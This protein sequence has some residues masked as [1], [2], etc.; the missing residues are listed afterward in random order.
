[1][2]LAYGHRKALGAMIAVALL[3]PVLAVVCLQ[4][5]HPVM[6]GGF[7]GACLTMAHTT[8]VGSLVDSEGSTSL[9]SR[10]VTA[11]VAFTALF[12]VPRSSLVLRPAASRPG[13]P[14]DSLNGCLRL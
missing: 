12:L 8:G 4:G 7:D 9:L 2:K 6:S 13:A 1:M 5:I 11:I 10:L 14:S 3:L